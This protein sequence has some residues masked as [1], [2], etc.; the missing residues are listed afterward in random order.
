MVF[1]YVG[2]YL[3][4]TWRHIPEESSR[5]QHR[6]RKSQIWRSYVCPFQVLILNFL[7]LTVKNHVISQVSR[8]TVLY[9]KGMP[10][11]QQ[12]EPLTLHCLCI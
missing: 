5:T 4:W 10:A 2:N 12:S 3:H 1:L 11:K 9:W 6:R 7:A 8:I